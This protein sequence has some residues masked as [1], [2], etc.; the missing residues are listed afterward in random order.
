[1]C[2]STTAI[3]CEQPNVCD[4]HESLQQQNREG[5]KKKMWRYGE[6]W[7]RDMT[8]VMYLASVRPWG[9]LAICAAIPWS[10]PYTTGITLNITGQSTEP[11]RYHW[12]VPD[13]FYQ[14]L[15]AWPNHRQGCCSV[16]E[17]QLFMYDVIGLVPSTAKLKKKGVLGWGCSSLVNFIFSYVIPGF[18]C[19]HCKKGRMFDNNSWIN[20]S[21]KKTD[22]QH[23]RQ[24]SYPCVISLD[25]A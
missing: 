15:W 21:S 7:Y 8:Q 3:K 14:Y 10:D 17:H 5:K 19:W 6:I 23:A 9:F 11:T 1:M 24:A 25:L 4:P 13:P 12:S 18:D 16:L 22:W 20:A 2:L